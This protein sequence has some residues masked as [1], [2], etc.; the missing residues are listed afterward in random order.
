[1][2]WRHRH[3]FPGR[4][5]IHVAVGSDVADPAHAVDVKYDEVRSA[6]GGDG[7]RRVNFKLRAGSRKGFADKSTHLALDQIEHHTTHAL[8]GIVNMFGNLDAAVLA[9]GQDAVVI[10]ESLRAGLLVRLDHILEQHSIL[11][12]DRD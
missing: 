4:R 8:V 9:D 6:G 7:G 3:C 5:K 12:L 2:S 11:G 1:L 10:Q